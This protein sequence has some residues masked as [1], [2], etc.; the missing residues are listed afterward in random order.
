MKK[1]TKVKKSGVLNRRTKAFI[2]SGLVALASFVV[3]G[4]RIGPFEH[5]G[6]ISEIRQFLGSNTA[7]VETVKQADSG[8]YFSD[9]NSIPSYSGKQSIVI[10]EDKPY[11]E[12]YDLNTINTSHYF[13]Y[14]GRDAYGR[15]QSAIATV[16]KAD[17]VA[18]ETRKGIDLP[19]PA[20]WVGR[21]KGGI[22]DRSHLIAYTLG[23]KNDLD[24]LV[25]GTVSF[26][27]KYMTEV[28]G[29]VRDY[30]KKTGRTVLYRVT[31]YYR[32]NEL[33]PVGVLMEASTGD[34]GFKRNRFVYNVQDGFEINYLT[35]QVK[36]K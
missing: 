15:A 36:E 31:P 27:Q 7:K 6:Y 29:D 14:S 17:L 34:G 26:N 9:G 2:L 5:K 24:N 30:I 3:F 18:S 35:G 33:L 11:F 13:K 8:L 20:G 12:V 23:G 28:E 10:N 1:K 16:S 19:D 21:S 32:G 22:Y 4:G 25:T